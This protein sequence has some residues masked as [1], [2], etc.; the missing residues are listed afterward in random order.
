MCKI[1]LLDCT[2]R[3]GGYY[4][5][6]DFSE[7]LINNYLFAMKEAKI[8]VV[9]I[10]FRSLKNDGFKG[11]CAFTSDEFLRKLKIY[12]SLSVSVMVNASELLSNDDINTILAKIFPNDANSSPVDIVRVACHYDEFEKVL[13]ASNWLKNK[14]FKVMFNLMQISDRT[15]IEIE[16]LLKKANNFPIDVFYF[17]DST[18]S[19]DNEKNIKIVELIKQNW[20]QSIG[21]HTHDN[22]G[23]ALS[24]TK[25]AI[26]SGVEWVDSTVLGMG[27]G[28]GNT[29]TELLSIE[30][31]KENS[32]L[33]P[34]IDLI[35][36]YFMP[37]QSTY[38]W[39]TNIFYYL[40][41]KYGIH[42]TFIQEMLQDNRYQKMN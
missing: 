11:A 16:N 10:G 40:A 28:P 19:I 25:S 21:C 13:N 36:Q 17:A 1:K 15:E 39:G 22:L 9:E 14:G 38:G 6:W 24:N 33:S 42:P 4:K 20:T 12:K 41:G 31:S 30:L 7:K 37:L 29:K 2:F 27:R 32:N 35:Y 26:K 8:D 3:D 5:L 23:L 18:G 34:L